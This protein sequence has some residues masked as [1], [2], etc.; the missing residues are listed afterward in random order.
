M[1]Q[2]KSFDVT[3]KESQLYAYCEQVTR[4]SKN[5]YNVGNFYIR[6]LMTGLKK[7]P[8]ERQKNETEIIDIVNTYLPDN[9][10]TGE[11]GS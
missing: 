4:N 7:D 11:N 9:K 6:Q 3:R 10:L 8:A 5:L 1:Y 2:V